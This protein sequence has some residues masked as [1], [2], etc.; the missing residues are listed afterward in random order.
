MFA[1]QRRGTAGLGSITGVALVAIL[2]AVGAT[3]MLKT[4][5]EGGASAVQQQLPSSCEVVCQ[6]PVPELKKG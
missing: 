4:Y 3:L 6:V 5:R 1:N 2:W